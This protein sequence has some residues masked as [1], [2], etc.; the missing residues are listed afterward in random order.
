MH[1]ECAACAAPC[2]EA[3]PEK[4]IHRHGKD[5]ALSGLPFLAFERGGCTWCGACAAACPVDLDTKPPRPGLGRVR[6]DRGSCLAWHGVICISC[7]SRC[8]YGAIDRDRS[9][10]TMLDAEACTGCGACIAACPVPGT[11]ALQKGVG[12]N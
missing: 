7:L 3:C 11:L 4:I 12:D 9:G 2:V 6:L 1:A 10:R 8:V 5:H